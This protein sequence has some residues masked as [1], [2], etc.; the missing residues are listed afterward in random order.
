ML[1]TYWTPD[2]RLLLNVSAKSATASWLRSML[3]KHNASM[4]GNGKQEP[5]GSGERGRDEI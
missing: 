5:E 4:D 1:K 3:F 2:I